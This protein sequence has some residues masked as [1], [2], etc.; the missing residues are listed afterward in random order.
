L[1][2]NFLVKPKVLLLLAIIISI[3]SPSSAWDQINVQFTQQPGTPYF[4]GQPEINIDAEEFTTLVLRIKA[5]QGGGARLYWATNFD[6]QMNQTKSLAFD[7]SRSNDFKEYTFN[8]RKQNG[9]WAGF[10]G[11]LLL[12][13]E[14]G[15]AGIE[16]GPTQVIPGNFW[17]GFKS[18]WR[19]FLV[20]EVPV[21]RT[22]NFIYGPKINGLSVNTYLYWLIILGSA[23]IAA[24][25]YY[26]KLP[27]QTAARNIMIVTLICWGAL[28][29]RQLLDQG[30]TVA[31]DWQTY[32]GK[33]LEEKQAATCLGDLYGFLKFAAANIP[34]GEGFNFVHPPQYYYFSEKANY[35]LYPTHYDQNGRYVL[36][37][38]PNRTEKVPSGKLLAT[39]KEG[40][41]ILIK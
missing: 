9:Y 1:C 6:P 11:Q 23:G 32:G 2:Y 40:E 35:Y 4:V 29:L 21:P 24:Y 15:P 33:S 16:L 10:V 28:D 41:Y 13:P 14:N 26:K 30:R 19:E 34:T 31:L 27:W 36:V 38:D 3:C 5:A 18:G 39:H 37:Y 12:V 8:L 17:T 20:F 25:T 22:V 7:L